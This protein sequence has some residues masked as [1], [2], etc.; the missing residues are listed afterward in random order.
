MRLTYK[1]E[2]IS[3]YGSTKLKNLPPDPLVNKLPYLDNIWEEE[4]NKLGQLED[5][6]ET[7]EADFGIPLIILNFKTPIYV[8]NAA[9]K[10]IV[11]TTL[12]G[13]DLLGRTISV[14][15]ED[16]RNN[17]FDKILFSN[18]GFTWALTRK[19]LL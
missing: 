2:K 12:A 7:F 5:L 10:K 16:N 4:R 14:Y 19:E 15:E 6:E 3:G 18:Y 17:W 8:K 1:Y 11:K 13:V 9:T